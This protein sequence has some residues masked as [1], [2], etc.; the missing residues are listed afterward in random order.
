MN[1]LSQNAYVKQNSENTI[2][3][4]APNSKKTA[5]V[6]L[7]ALEAKAFKHFVPLFQLK[8]SYDAHS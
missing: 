7:E 2:L 5:N 3:F 8:Q 1:N 4:G 6:S